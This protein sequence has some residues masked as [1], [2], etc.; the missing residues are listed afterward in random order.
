[1]KREINKKTNKLQRQKRFN[2]DDD[3]NVVGAVHVAINAVK[4]LKKKYRIIPIPTTT[5]TGG[6]VSP[7]PQNTLPN[8]P[9]SN[10]DIETFVKHH[11]IPHF[12]GVF[13]RDNLPRA[14]P[15]KHECMIVNQDSVQ[16]NG[17]HWVCFVKTG[18]NVF[19][20]DSFG[21]LP[22]ALEVLAY[23]GDNCRIYYNVRQ[24]QQFDTIICGHLCIC[25]LSEYYRKLLEDK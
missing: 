4:R 10:L 8:R 7:S 6:S 14:K 22:P 15:W 9:L 19:Y 3:D 2:D 16:N 13:M 5:T 12:R 1:M 17:T 24:Y 20:F 21:K 25:F 18:N 23:L 11:K